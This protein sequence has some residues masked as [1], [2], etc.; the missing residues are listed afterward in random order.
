MCIVRVRVPRDDQQH[1]L[2]AVASEHLDG[3]DRLSVVPGESY[4]LLVGWQF[5][6]GL[7]PFSEV[8]YHA[9]D[10][11]KS[12]RQDRQQIWQLS[13]KIVSVRPPCAVDKP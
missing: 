3:V 12:Y 5:L 11:A 6:W 7:A 13:W 10:R 1:D 8:V 4:H 2:V 9:I